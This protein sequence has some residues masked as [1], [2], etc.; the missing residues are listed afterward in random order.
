MRRLEVDARPEQV[1]AVRR[2]AAAA[3]RAAGLPGH[4]VD[5]VALCVSELASM[6]VQ[7]ARTGG[8]GTLRMRIDERHDG[9]RVAVH[10]TG[11]PAGAATGA[12]VLDPAIG[13]A[14]VLQL[15]D[16]VDVVPANDGTEVRLR[17]TPARRR[18]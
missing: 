9:L 15:A 5:D 17:F 2:V 12:D 1:A 18:P 3:A 10:D 13:L 8:P 16:R 6:G 14:L 11:P 4:R 7:H